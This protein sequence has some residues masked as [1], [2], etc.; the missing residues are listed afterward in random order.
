MRRVAI[1]LALVLGFGWG[2]VMASEIN[3]LGFYIG[4]AIGRSHVRTTLAPL[5]APYELDHSDT[6][7]KVFVGYRP[8]HLFAAELAYV[9]FGHRKWPASFGSFT[10]HGDVFQRAETLS[11]LVFAP[12]PLPQLDVY[13]R[14]G[15]A[16][17]ESSGNPYLQC[18]PGHV[19]PL[20]AFPNLRFDNTNTEFYY[21]AGVGLHISDWIVR[22][23]YERIND[24][25]DD[26]DLLSAGLAWTF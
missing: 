11:G 4:G 21:G 8:I 1:L 6:G 23:E 16:R 22:L 3:A 15:I 2:R 24:S 17:L 20:I 25:R 10:L 12:I 26:P 5:Y 18:A 7:W 19:C 13:A 14:A 9:D